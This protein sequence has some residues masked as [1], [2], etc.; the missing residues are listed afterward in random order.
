MRNP[1]R[2]RASQRSVNDD[3]FVR[4]FGA[5]ALLEMAK[6]IT[7]PWG[8][9]VFLRSAPG[10]GKSTLLR[11]LTPRPLRLVGRMADEDR[12]KPTV[13]ALRALEAL[14]EREPQIL[15]S[16]VP[17]TP[18]YRDLAEL[19]RGNSMFRALLNS[20]I[21]ISTLR[22][23]LER[24]E[25]IYPDDLATI[26]VSWAP[27][28][29]ATIP[30][31]A[32]GQELFDWAS[33][34]ESGFYDQIDDLGA[35]ETGLVGHARL[36]GLTWFSKA[37]FTDAYGEV[38]SRRVLLF[39]DLQWLSDT[40]R[41]GL[42]DIL[43]NARETCGIWVAERMEALKPSDL[44]SEGVLEDRDYQG[45]LQLERLWAADRKAKGFAKFIEQIAD[46]RVEKADGFDNSSFRSLI[47]DADSDLEWRNRFD[48]K[49][50]EIE[51]RI[52]SKVQNVD[53]YAEWM[54][55]AANHDGGSVARSIRWRAV[56]ILVERDL[57]K[58]QGTFDFETLPEEELEDKLSGVDRAAEHFA[59]VEMEAPVYFGRDALATVSSW[60]VEQYLEVAG[61]LFDE[62]A[63]SAAGRRGPPPALTPERQDALIRK[64]ADKRWEGLVR[65][66]PQGY[67]ARLFLEAACEYCRN[68]TFRVTAPYP[69]GVTGFAISMSERKRLI[70][71]VEGKLKE[72]AKLRSVLTSLVAQNILIPRIDHRNKG[73]SF[74]LFYMNRLLC[75]H[76][77]L[78]LG[79]G[80]WREKTLKELVDWMEK[81]KAAIEEG[82]LV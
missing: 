50:T 49:S 46:L 7:D 21:V 65:R 11:L 27:D 31:R 55:N 3:E 63:A 77:T 12:V 26:S 70:E 48:A 58:Q 57:N 25:R 41:S 66:L 78:P 39:D 79:Y 71:G 52:K 5:G 32:N 8:S 80:G 35:A 24:S 62:I 45:V 1:F 15:G 6:D 38:D 47:A 20:R 54:Q 9:V 82:S 72:V 59:R 43:T 2:I 28:S 67:E 34:I 37:T 44:L 64:V 14:E 60:N 42:I 73:K 75:V 16:L 69:P 19:D 18:E 23:L 40:Q 30:A 17:F 74:M 10:G 29:G 33:E 56:E 36:D 81:G 76:A 4:L 13:E 68:Q 22:A 61:D 53:R 51:E